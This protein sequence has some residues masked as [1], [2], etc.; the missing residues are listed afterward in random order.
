MN[1]V[2]APMQSRGPLT[3]SEIRAQVN[4]IQEVMN[5]VMHDKEHY[6]II[7]GC[8]KPSLWKPGAEKLL[9]TFRISSEPEVLDLSTPDEARYRVIRRGTSIVSG[10]SVGAGLGE[11]SS[12]EEKYKWRKA[13]C[14]EE[15]D[16]T[17]EDRRRVK[18]GKGEGKV[19]TTKQ[20]RTN[21]A[22]LANTVLKMADKRAYVGLALNVTAASDCFTQ[23]VEDLPEGMD[24]GEPKKEPIKGPTAKTE[25]P[26]E[27]K[28]K[29][30]EKTDG[31][32]TFIP[33]AISEKP[34]DGAKGPYTKFGI[35]S[36]EGAW[37]GTFDTTLGAIAQ[38]AKNKKVA[39]EVG[40]VTDG[41]WL[42]VVTLKLA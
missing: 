1:E 8:A 22:D 42:N 17:P 13:L 25:A 3:A 21:P 9:M 41:K 4:L 14:D 18:Y 6:G 32:V 16:A 15:F 10:V 28:A 34:G 26:A 11:C 30:A 7:P 40:F 2:L 37:Y 27:A 39:I 5:S 35:K 36:P 38:D 23:D 24:N 12:S 33:A 19:Y 20:I 29:A 31:T